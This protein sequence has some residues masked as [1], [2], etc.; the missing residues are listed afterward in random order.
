MGA[1]DQQFQQQA[2]CVSAPLPF[3]AWDDVQTQL[4]F[5]LTQ[6]NIEQ[7]IAVFEMPVE[8]P[9]GHAQMARHALD[10][11]LVDSAVK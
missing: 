3:Q 10:A 11:H 5:P 7:L 1:L 9:F 2:Q 4:F 6:Q 8:A